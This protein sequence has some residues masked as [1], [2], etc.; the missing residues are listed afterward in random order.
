MTHRTVEGSPESKGRITPDAP[1]SPAPPQGEREA[2]E[3]AERASDLR[4]DE[5]EGDYLNP[6]VQAAWEGW[7]ARAALSAATPPAGPLSDADFD[8]IADACDCIVPGRLKEAINKRLM[9]RR[10]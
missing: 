3:H 2:F 8:A 7:Q 1:A 9:E 5:E 10:Q 4:R 6:C